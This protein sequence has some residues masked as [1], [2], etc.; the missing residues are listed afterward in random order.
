MSPVDSDSERG[1]TEE[2]EDPD[3]AGSESTAVPQ[4]GVLGN[5][6]RTRPTVRS[7]RRTKQDPATKPARSRS[8]SRDTDPERSEEPERSPRA[9]GESAPS[10]TAELEALARGGIA[11][12]GEAASL[13]LRIAGRAA[14]AVRDAVERR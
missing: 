5:L 10:G 7:P 6:P 4:A 2:P 11:I 12:A 8:E 3:E 1:D 14:A 9:E 13:G